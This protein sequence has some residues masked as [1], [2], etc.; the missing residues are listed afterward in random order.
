MN[1]RLHMRLFF[2]NL[3][4][5]AEALE[6]CLLRTTATAFEMYFYANDLLD[7]F[8]SFDTRITHPNF[9]PAVFFCKPL[10]SGHLY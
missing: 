1:E 4:D 9:P 8:Y 2:C 5:L 10:L 6:L 3:V 7:I